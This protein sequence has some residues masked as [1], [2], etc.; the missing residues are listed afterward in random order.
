MVEVL[1]VQKSIL[2]AIWGSGNLRTSEIIFQTILLSLL[3]FS[4]YLN[5]C[6]YKIMTAL[7]DYLDLLFRDISQQ[8][9]EDVGGRKHGIPPLLAPP[10]MFV[11]IL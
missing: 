7:L 8:V 6:I 1:K 9:W 11:Y 4:E 5:T 3:K 2:Y 10:L